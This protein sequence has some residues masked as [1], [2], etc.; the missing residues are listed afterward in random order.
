VT[1][2]GETGLESV[3]RDNCSSLLTT[4]RYFSMRHGREHHFSPCLFLQ[5]QSRGNESPN[6]ATSTGQ[7]HPQLRHGVMRLSQ[8]RLCRIC[9]GLPRP[10]RPANR[11]SS[12][13]RGGRLFSQ[14][15]CAHQNQAVGQCARRSQPLR[16]GRSK[17]RFRE[18]SSQIRA[19][20]ARDRPGGASGEIHGVRYAALSRLLRCQMRWVR[21]RLE[22]GP[23]PR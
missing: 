19:C 9:K 6:R 13:A 12:R 8:C 3:Y 23:A 22:I 1:W 10:R 5:S 16:S 4:S 18:G 2:S 17:H 11:A 7:E 20:A 21:R 14:A 15:N